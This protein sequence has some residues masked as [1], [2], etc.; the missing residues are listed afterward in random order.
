MYNKN[1]QSLL[2]IYTHTHNGYLVH[3]RSCV[4]KAVTPLSRSAKLYGGQC[5][6]ILGRVFFFFFHRLLSALDLSI[7]ISF[8]FPPLRVFVIF[9]FFF[10]L[11]FLVLHCLFF[12]TLMP[13]HQYIR[14]T[15]HTRTL[16]C[17]SHFCGHWC[18]NIY[19]AMC[20]SHG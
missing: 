17:R 11:P 19:P 20:I 7:S 12:F 15:T 4:W 18:P 9:F 13:L 5:P 8:F 10:F 6:S 16:L 2:H 3:E 14:V 1:W